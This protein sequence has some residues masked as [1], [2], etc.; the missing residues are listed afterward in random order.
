M[1]SFP[2]LTYFPDPSESF[3]ETSEKCSCCG[4]M[5]GREY[6]QNVYCVGE[7]PKHHCP[8][9]IAEGSMSEPQTA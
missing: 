3:R 9:C 1:S 4:Q 2:R 5:R 8:W 7:N 6:K